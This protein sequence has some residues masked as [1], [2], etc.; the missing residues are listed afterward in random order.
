M[1]PDYLA[2]FAG[3]GRLYGRTGL[4]RLAAANVTVI[5]LGGVGSWAVEAL[6]RS[7]VGALTLVDM[8]DVCVSN[9][10]RQLHAVEG[11]G[12]RAKADALR[13]RVLAINPACRATAIQRF[14]TASTAD[15][16]LAAPTPPDAV[17][18]AIDSLQDKCLLLAACRARAIPVVTS[19]GC[20]GKRDATAIRVTDLSRSGADDLLRIVR[21]KLRREH[22]FP[23]EKKPF[24]IPCVWSEEL[25]ADAPGGCEN[26]TLPGALTPG[27]ADAAD[28]RPN[29]EWGRGTA[30]FVSGAFGFAAAGV[31][32]SKIAAG[33]WPPAQAAA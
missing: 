31:V 30:V 24:G 23:R 2:R 13:E 21:R 7:G 18:D 27:D 19:G 15:A 16:I 5:G 22:A 17:V 28:M 32:V 4:E 33:E 8:D 25:A 29:C 1:T 10:N 14:F 20:A 6:A 9:T 12:G 3:V 26:A 11:A